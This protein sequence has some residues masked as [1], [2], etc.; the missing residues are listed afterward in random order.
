MA[1]L[2][3]DAGQIDPS[4]PFDVLPA[5]WYPVCVVESEIVESQ[6]GKGRYL[7]IV[8]Q[9]LHGPF[10]NR[11]LW[12]NLCM[13]STNPTA[14]QIAK[15]QFSALSRSVG[16]ASPRD[17]SELH[18]RPL[19]ALVRVEGDKAKKAGPPPLPGPPGQ[20]GQPDQPA[21][22]KMSNPRNVIKGYATFAD[23]FSPGGE[24]K[25]AHQ[26]Q[27]V[28]GPVPQV[29]VESTQPVPP[30]SQPTYVNGAP[31]QGGKPW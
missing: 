1:E 6:S 8:L 30:V 18:M 7:K 12:D 26:T 10:K 29:P 28:P 22:L 4:Q 9:V 11:K 20:S 27:S 2:D 16:I 17:T 23:K 15:G 21:P 19:A 3:F 24:Q 5:G 13:W 31:G 14:A 25:N